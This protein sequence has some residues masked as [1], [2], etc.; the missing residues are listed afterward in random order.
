MIIRALTP[1]DFQQVIELGNRVHG[2]GYLDIDSLTKIYKMGI[3]NNINAHF[4]AENE[5]SSQASTANNQTSIIGFRLTYAAGQWPIDKWCTPSEWPVAIEDMCYFKCNTVTES[6]RGQG[7]GSKLLQASIKAVK[8]QGARAG[9]SHL[10]Q[11]SP[12]NSAVSYF[13][14]AG[15]KLIKEHPS[16]WNQQSDETN[17][18]ICVLCGDDCHCTACEMVLEFS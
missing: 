3:K 11:Q 16:R 6:L 1:D 7:I 13:T 15:G 9:V 18:Y 17:D 14:H 10:W 12:N 8:A 4:I 5:Q 2:E